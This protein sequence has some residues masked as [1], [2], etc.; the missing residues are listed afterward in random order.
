[1]FSNATIIR[2][3]RQSLSAC[4]RRRPS[5]RGLHGT[6][7]VF[8]LL[9][10]LP[11]G[12][13]TAQSSADEQ[14]QS[15]NL[16]E[17]VVTAPFQG[18]KAETAL[19]FTVLS[20]E[21]LRE[22]VTNNLGDTLRNEAGINNASFG[23]GVGHP[24][25]RGQSGNRVSVLQNG[26]GVT[27]ASNVSADHANGV[28][29][30]LAN[31]L[32]II[33]GPATLLYGSGA[34]GGVV[35]VI[36]DRI[37]DRLPER[38]DFMVEQQR[39]SVSEENKTV[40]R[41]NGTSGSLAFHLDAFTRS[42]E[43][44][45]VPGLAIDAEALEALEEL[46]GE[47]H[48]EEEEHEEIE[49]TNG[50]IRN[51]NGEGRGGTAGLSWVGSRGF[52]GFSLSELALD[53]GLPFGSHAHGHE[54]EEE[55]DHDHGMM[56]AEDDEH[57]HEEEVDVRIDLEQTRYD[58]KG[59]FNFDG[60]LFESFVASAAITDYSHREIEIAVEEEGDD[61]DEMDM[62]E[63]D[64]EGGHGTLFKHEGME[65]R[66]HLT[67]AATG[68]WEGVWGLQF[69]ST[70]FSAVGEEAYIYPADI[71]AFGL[72]GVERYNA[73]G[74]TAEFGLR[75]ENGGVDIGSGCSSDETATSFSGSLIYDLNIETNL[76]F[77]LSRS[78]RNPT[79]EEL[80]SNVAP[81][82]CTPVMEED[83][84]LHAATNLR[85]VG[86]PMLAV[87]TS[88]NLEFGW[89]RQ[90]AGVNWEF[91]VYRNNVADY[92][93]LELAD[94]EHHDDDEM[95]MGMES[96]EH[97]DEAP[98]AHYEARDAL[99]TG[100]EAGLSLP[101]AEL[102]NSALELS[103][104]ADLVMAEFDDGGNVPRIPPAKFGGE[105]RWFGQNWNAHLHAMRA[106]SQS[107]VGAAELETPGYTL[108]SLYAD[109]H[110]PVGG[111]GSE[112]KVFL[113][114]DNLLDEEVRNHASYLK[115]YA[116]EPGRAV[117]FGVRY[118]Y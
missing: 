41:L 28:E 80:Y 20:G 16:E 63:H 108:L 48:A 111:D 68:A 112:L 97:E 55:D 14:T 106:A 30:S 93:Y 114:G 42:N 49:N 78:Q 82:A 25:I 10:L 105:L 38:T 23:T 98:V 13:A 7:S 74:W 26:V 45:K 60:G 21:E 32:E 12:A 53:Y 54:E 22:Q 89:R 56:G 27:D 87:E 31:R 115:N 65:G 96:E 58:F 94:E 69:S 1:M 52:I 104:F 86:N 61:H 113:R 109:Y 46:A 85:E 8:T 99:F 47:E 107:D 62:D 64:E 44:V 11:A 51:S 116:P 4:L 33:R 73:D 35:N 37:P 103:L 34:V 9:T 101:L 24:V 77:G 76:V 18:T 40:L 2:F 91:T 3:I 70:E 72:F 88:Q 36:D 50:F 118:E 17:I 67:R 79:V 75:L 6:L 110:F 39:N 66:L 71:S 117:V 95:G 15:E 92:V 84:V 59:G 100:F 5:A 102:S 19:P 83:L 43:N 81:A 29:A 90:G 57:G